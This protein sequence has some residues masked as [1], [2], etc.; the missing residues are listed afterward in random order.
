M[1]ECVRQKILNVVDWHVSK[2]L[3]PASQASQSADLCMF[4]AAEICPWVIRTKVPYVALNIAADI[5]STAVI[6]VS[7]L[8]HNLGTCR[9][10]PRAVG[11]HII[12]DYVGRLGYR[13]SICRLD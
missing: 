12:N 2:Y 11:V 3:T 6:L 8:H 9:P 7:W 10:C 13:A 5:E 4:L 1:R